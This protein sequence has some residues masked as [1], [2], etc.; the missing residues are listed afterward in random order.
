MIRRVGPAQQQVQTPRRKYLS[1][2]Q[3]LKGRHSMKTDCGVVLLLV[4]LGVVDGMGA[5]ATITLSPSQRFQT[6]EG[7]GA[8]STSADPS[9]LANDLGQSM[10]RFSFPTGYY[11]SQGNYNPGALDG[12]I[13]RMN[14]L[15]GAG[16]TRWITTIWTPPSWMKDLTRDV[17]ASCWDGY[18]ACGG[19]VRADMYGELANMIVAYCKAVKQRT[20]V[21]L[22][23]FSI[24][25][26]LAFVEPYISCVYTPAEYRDALKVVGAAMTR[27]GLSTRLFGAEDMLTS[28]TANP[29]FGTIN[30]DAEA[31]GYLDACAVHGYSN[32]VSPD[33]AVTAAPLWSRLGTMARQMGNKGVWMTETS[34]LPETWDGAMNL[35]GGMYA[36]LRWGNLSAW[37]W[38]MECGSGAASGSLEGLLLSN[39]THSK[40]SYT[41]KQFYKWIRPDAARI[42]ASFSGDSTNL[43]AVAFHHQAGK[44]LT[45]VVMNKGASA[46]TVSFAGGDCPATL[47]HFRT[48]A[49]ENCASLGSV[50]SGNVTI[51]ASSVNT[52]YATGYEPSVAVLRQPRA[53][54]P[55]PALTPGANSEFDLRGKRISAGAGGPSSG[56]AVVPNG[57]GY[58]TRIRTAGGR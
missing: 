11:P 39:C 1:L 43:C 42:N 26:E 25:N 29:Y 41:A 55:A 8:F 14:A 7:F 12:Q 6:I 32:G 50:A 53:V 4:V 49:N 45:V 22:Y 40:R 15:K 3:I 38:W 9:F 13:S 21:D 47:Q 5:D 19:H 24:Q 16:I 2:A 33:P 54:P 27:E 35:A 10:S 46:R 57:S 58:L 48:S 56:I 20:G 52:F 34:G 17:P 31:R 36:A 44:T 23:A 30:Q 18:G 51:A 28:I 37:V